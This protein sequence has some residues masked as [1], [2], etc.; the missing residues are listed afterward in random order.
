[1]AKTKIATNDFEHYL[2]DLE[3]DY[4]KGRYW[5]APALNPKNE[6]HV[7]VLIYGHHTSLERSAGLAQ[8]L[9]RFG[10]VIMPDLPGLGGMESFYKVD[11]LPTL[12]NYALYLDKF[13]KQY[14][15][16]GQTFS[17]IGLSFG[18]LVTTRFLQKFPNWCHRV[19]LVIS[20]M[21]F[22]SGQSM[23]FSTRRRWWYLRGT[24]LA[25]TRLGA[26]IFRY[27]ILNAG[28][29]RVFYTRTLSAQSKLSQYSP[30]LQ[31]KLLALEIK[32][33]HL[34]DVRTWAFT[35][36]S[37]MNCD[38]SQPALDLSLHHITPKVDQFLNNK[39]NQSR[40][41]LVYNEVKFF[42][43]NLT[44]HAPTIIADAGEI[45]TLIPSDLVAILKKEA[46]IKLK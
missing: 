3:I 38:L 37:M 28:V 36:Q 17:I 26:W 35:A 7:I 14:L 9:R 40:L 24:V 33:W 10:Q 13:L 32:L 39:H 4:L 22:L 23:K 43:I 8:Y 31:R 27:L 20:L 6:T 44:T 5:R 2:F 15:K 19:R 29:L 16:D 34:N 21:G 12:D 46:F 1:M 11:S 18:F 25:K 41:R 42:S 30:N 45:E